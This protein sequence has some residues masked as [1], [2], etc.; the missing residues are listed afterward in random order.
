M[1]PHKLQTPNKL[2]PDVRLNNPKPETVH[3][4][5]VAFVS[6]DAGA[7]KGRTSKKGIM[8]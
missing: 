7:P 2:I 5:A 8:A 6:P 3:Q 4:A 1:K